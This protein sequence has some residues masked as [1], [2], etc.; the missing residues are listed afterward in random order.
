MWRDDRRHASLEEDGGEGR[1]A[2]PCDQRAMRWESDNVYGC[3]H[4]LDDSSMRVTDRAIDVTS[5]GGHGDMAVFE[6]GPWGTK[7][8]LVRPRATPFS[9]QGPRVQQQSLRTKATWS[10]KRTSRSRRSV[11]ETP[12]YPLLLS[13]MCAV[14]HSM[15]HVTCLARVILPTYSSGLKRA[16]PQRARMHPPKHTSNLTMQTIF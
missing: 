1:V 10:Q 6:V 8:D 15:L 14:S 2:L 3:C 16:T 12:H 9:T 5:G 13:V 4:S 11:G 7:V